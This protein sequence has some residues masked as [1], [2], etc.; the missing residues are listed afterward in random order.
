MKQGFTLL[1]LIIVVAIVALV[2]GMISIRFLRVNQTTAVENSVLTL[3][4]YFKEARSRSFSGQTSGA[5]NSWGVYVD[6]AVYDNPVLFADVDQDGTFSSGDTTEEIFLDEN[7]EVF[8]CL[9][10]ATLVPECGVIFSA[11]SA[12]ASLFTFTGTATAP[13]TSLQ[14]DIQSRADTAVQENVTVTAPSGLV[15][16]SVTL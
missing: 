9:I 4:S 13:F 14:I 3:S 12:E 8:Q 15:V 6:P 1:E 16:T 7:A 11:P 10:N 2:G 5:A